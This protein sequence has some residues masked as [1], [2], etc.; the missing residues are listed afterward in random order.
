MKA[1]VGDGDFRCEIG[2]KWCISRESFHLN[3][4]GTTAYA[5][6][7]RRAVGKL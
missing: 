6:A 2:A 5:E 4:T 3:S 1:P 7:F